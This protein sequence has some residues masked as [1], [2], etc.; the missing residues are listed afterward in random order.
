MEIKN[1]FEDVCREYGI[2]RAIKSIEERASE[3][4]WFSFE[5]NNLKHEFG[6]ISN[7]I[8]NDVKKQPVLNLSAFYLHHSIEGRESI[9]PIFGLNKR[10]INNDEFSRLLCIHEISHSIDMLNLKEGLEIIISDCDK[11]VGLV[12]QGIANK[13]H[14][15]LGGFGEDRFHN[16]GFGAILSAL[17][18]RKYPNNHATKLN[19]SLSRNFLDDYSSELIC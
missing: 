19:E 17:I 18:R 11:S 16:E 5:L 4:C 8:L 7:E 13:V 2:P 9:N 14:D 15:Q 6:P 12:I 3:I 10:H 1:L